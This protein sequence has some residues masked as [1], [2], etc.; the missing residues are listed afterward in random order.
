MLWLRKISGNT[1]ASAGME[2]W[3][4]RK[5][6]AIAAMG[7]L[8]PLLVLGIVH[9]VNDAGSNAQTARMLQ[10]A[11]YTCWGVIIFN[12]TMVLTVGIGCVVVMVMKGPG[13]VA[14]GYW[15]SHSDT[16]RQKM[17]STAQADDRRNVP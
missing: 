10:T 17:E 13:Y 1:R 2:W 16:P 8:L 14:D 9:L 3:L 4:W 12:W 6:P 11:N 5:L 7:T 15:V